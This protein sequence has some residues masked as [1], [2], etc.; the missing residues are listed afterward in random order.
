MIRIIKGTYGLRRGNKVEAMT[1]G[2]EP[3]SLSSE[4]EKELVNQG[5]AE[6]VDKPETVAQEDPD[7]PKES[8]ESERRL[9]EKP[10]D[11]KNDRKKR[12]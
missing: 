9:E 12:K 10:L 4:R 11:N 1:P 3:F 8:H 5:T 2:T 6:Y 7:I